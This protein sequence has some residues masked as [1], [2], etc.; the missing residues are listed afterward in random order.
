MINKE[1]ILEAAQL[2]VI[3]N[4]LISKFKQSCN[5]NY[6][7]FLQEIFINFVKDKKIIDSFMKGKT[8]YR[9]MP[10]LFV[11]SA[12]TGL[13]IACYQ[14]DL[15]IFKDIGDSQNSAM[16]KYIEKHYTLIRYEKMLETS[17]QPVLL[18]HLNHLIRES[19]NLEVGMFTGGEQLGDRA[20]RFEIISDLSFIINFLST[21]YFEWAQMSNSIKIFQTI[22]YKKSSHVKETGC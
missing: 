13:I 12:F 20:K 4:D 5:E 19:D 21:F 8:K 7:S 1:N 10:Q 22:E 2:E 3:E 17:T 18:D 11:I 9:N 15:F 16:E 14:Y 6:Y